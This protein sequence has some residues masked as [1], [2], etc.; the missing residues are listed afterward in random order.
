M[1]VGECV[2]VGGGGCCIREREIVRE[3][4]VERERSA[5]VSDMRKLHKK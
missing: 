1:G 3:K 4:A 5:C 2:G